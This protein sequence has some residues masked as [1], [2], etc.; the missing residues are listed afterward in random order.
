MPTLGEIGSTFFRFEML[1][2]SVWSL[3]VRPQYG[4]VVVK[5]P[6][7][8]E[9]LLVGMVGSHISKS[10]A[11]TSQTRAEISLRD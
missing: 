7:R 5:R 6:V 8:C 2:F 11:V 9:M 10:L 4:L 3:T 1:R